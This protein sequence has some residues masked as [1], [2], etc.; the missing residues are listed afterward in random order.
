ME[1]YSS[2]RRRA[3]SAGPLEHAP[4][5]RVEGQ[6]AAGDLGAPGE[7]RRRARRGRRQVDADAAERLGRDPLV[8]LDEG[9]EEV[10]GVEDGA[11]EALGERL[12]ADD[13]LLGL[14]GEAFEVH[15]ATVLR[16]CRGGSRARCWSLA[17]ARV[18]LVDGVEEGGRGR[19][20]PGSSSA[21]R[22]TF[23]RTRRSPPLAALEARHPLAG[24]AD[25]AARLGPGGDREEEPLA[26]ERRHRAPRRRGAPRGGSPGA[27]GS[28]SRPSRV[29][30]GCGRTRTTRTR[31]RAPPPCPPPWPRSRIR[32]P[33]STPAGIV[34]SRRRP[35]TS[36]QA[37]GAVEGLLEGDLDRG[38][39][40]GRPRVAA[41]A[42]CAPAGRVPAAVVD[43]AHAGQ[44]VLEARAA[45]GRPSRR[46]S[47]PRPPAAPGARRGAR[48][49]RPAKNVRKNSENS[50]ASP[51]NSKRTPPGP[52][53]RRP[54]RPAGSPRTGRPGRT[55]RRPAARPPGRT[56]PSARRA[57]RTA[58]ASRGRRGPRWPR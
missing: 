40:R 5:A 12:G 37:G 44:D 18:G 45:R 26:V 55:G 14:L 6:R 53:R 4:G 27:R 50:P 1:T 43:A 49:C 3:S 47:A 19:P 30:T 24:E 56:P 23:T 8:V 9:G 48:P 13:R 35:S 15:G 34:T 16:C 58:S 17:P 36:T 41:G 2:P 10:L 57:R 38:L 32:L 39:G 52:A 20:R 42:G 22:T 21:G 46:A 11:L 7:E 51:A 25:R 29:K 31:S 28:G 33:V 54:P